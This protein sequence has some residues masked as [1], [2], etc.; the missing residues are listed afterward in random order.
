MKTPATPNIAALRALLKQ[1][2]CTLA[3]VSDETGISVSLL[4]KIKSGARSN[5]TIDT[6][7]A[8]CKFLEESA[9]NNR[10]AAA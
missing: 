5:P 9:R 3:E 4:G 8:L 1:T 2:Q 7:N 10:R 6:Y